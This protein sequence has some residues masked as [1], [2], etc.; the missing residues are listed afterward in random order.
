MIVRT[1]LRKRMKV[2]WLDLKSQYQTIEEEVNRV[3]EEV[4]ESGHYILGPNVRTLEEEI[5]DYCEVK[6]A[7]GVASG[8][9]ALRLS[10]LSLGVGEGDEVIVT[11]FTFIATAEVIT[12]VGARPIF[13]DIEEKTFNLDPAKIEPALTPRTKAI[14][15]VHLYGQ[16]V[17]MGKIMSIAKENHL[18]V[19]ED[20]AQAFGAEYHGRSGRPRKLGSIGDIGCLSFFPTKNL[21][22]YGDGGMVLTSDHKV[23]RKIRMLRVHG[24]DSNYGHSL[25]GYNSRLD[26][27]QAAILRVK[28]RYVDK[29]MKMRCQNA[30]LYN[31]LFSSCKIPVTTPS[32]VPYARHSF[33]V[34]T[35]RMPR[36]DELRDY[37]KKKGIETKVYYRLPLHLE[38]AYRSLGYNQGDLPIAEKTSKEVLSLPIYP[39]LSKAQIELVVKEIKNFFR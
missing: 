7:I 11:P 27:L 28:L 8:T 19:I 3:V 13:V 36:R 16:A 2:Y 17:D 34:Y 21:G 18:K 24:L 39:E 35:V 22:A 1:R 37:L 31:K 9:D 12:Q 5:A 32:E 10:L 20:V 4:L 6:Y 14:M 30:S 38:K 25:L 29:W 23:A 26:E 33:C 15:P